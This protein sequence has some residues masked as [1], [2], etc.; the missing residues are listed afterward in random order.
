MGA[1]GAARRRV[2]ERLRRSRLLLQVLSESDLNVL[3]T[4]DEGGSI[5]VPVFTCAGEA[6][7][8]LPQAEAM[9]VAVVPAAEIFRRTLSTAASCILINPASCRW[10]LSLLE[11]KALAIGLALATTASTTL[12]SRIERELE[13]YRRRTGALG[14][15]FLNNFHCLLPGG[16]Y[17]RIFDQEE[18]NQPCA[19]ARASRKLRGMMHAQFF[20]LIDALIEELGL[21]ANE[22]KRLQ[23]AEGREIYDY[24][25][26]LYVRLREEGF[27]HYPDLTA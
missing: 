25:F 21:D 27:K 16:L 11:I 14:G 1:S 3:A 7:A 17:R 9:T 6:R 15:H 18:M 8:W 23:S 22:I 26:P 13:V 10:R 24:V 20:G 4:R 2:L 5:A 12:K 19:D